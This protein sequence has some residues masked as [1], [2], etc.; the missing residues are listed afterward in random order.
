MPAGS[1]QKSWQY[2]AK[3]LTLILLGSVLYAFDLKTFVRAG[4]LIPGGFSGLALL[5][6][7]SC[8]RFG[9]FEAPYSILNYALNAVPVLICFKV[10]GKKFTL[11]SCLMIVVS[12]L[13]TDFMPSMFIEFIQLHD[14]LLSAVFGG[15]L[16]ALAMSLCLTAGATSGG[17]DF[18]AIFFAEKYHKDTW[19]Y[20]FAGNFLILAVAGFLFTLDKA[21]YS[22]I[23]QFTTTIALSFFY[24]GY[25]QNTLFII[26]NKPDEIY[27]VIYEKTNHGGTSFKG[28]GHY[29]KTERTMLYSVV[30]ADQVAPLIT[31][32]Q[33][34]DPDSFINVLKTETITGRFYLS[35]RD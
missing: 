21:L 11:Y 16:N 33:N 30:S 28:V 6:Q 17:T 13:L 27:K 24:R 12:S 23:F 9:G 14:N 19:N 3:R 35:P 18:I 29:M 31:A 15:L 7:E 20:I 5:I 22:I 25:Q 10:I 2:T 8:L 1:K 32:I 34:V 4:A 26:T